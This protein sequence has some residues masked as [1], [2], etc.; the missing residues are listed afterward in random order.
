MQQ[1][2]NFFLRNKNFLLFVVLFSLALNITFNNNPYQHSA[3]SNSFY[4]L[5][6]KTFEWRSA[7]S[8]FWDLQR[9]NKVLIK[10][11]KRLHKLLF[12]QNIKLN[13]SPPTS[14]YNLQVSKVIKNSFNLRNNYLTILKGSA[15]GISINN[16][17]INSIGV[18]GV[19]DKVSEKYSR[20][21]SILSE[22]TRINA[23]LKNT[24]YFGIISWDTKKTNVVQLNDIQDLANLKKGDTIV[25]SG[26][27]A[28]FPENI[29]VGTVANFKLN[30]TQDLYIIDVLL[31][32]DMCNLN[33][34]YLIQNKDRKELQELTE[35]N[36]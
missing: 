3:I 17:V 31:F 10:E 7:V 16:G 6:S 33:H 21:L 28:I 36:E 8:S 25:T 18:V 12:N 34:V 20:V 9:E 24:N 1:I 13:D 23:K 35:V 22:K 14:L 2:I 5:T 15:A 11:N 19:V 29:P 30:E 26:Y 4:P 27:S 32:N